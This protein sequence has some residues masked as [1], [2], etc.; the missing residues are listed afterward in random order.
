MT[1]NEIIKVNISATDGIATTSKVLTINI[2]A[3]VSP[4]DAPTLS[5]PT[6]GSVTEDASTSVVTGLLTGSDPENDTLVYSVDGVT[7]AS[8]SYTA[9]GSYGTLVLTSATGAYTYSINNAATS[10]QSLG[11]GAAV[12][13][14]FSVGLSDGTNK[15]ASQNL[16]PS[17]L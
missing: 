2:E 13:E 8:G 4:N 14:V 10:V 1:I 5:V 12:T 6:G 3:P 17:H 11:S 15:T 9:V 16:T 7:A